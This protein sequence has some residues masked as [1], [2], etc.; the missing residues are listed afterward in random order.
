MFV[1]FEGKDVLVIGG[2]GVGT[3]RAKKFLKAKAKVKVFSLDF[4]DEL[5]EISGRVELI[6]GDV[7][8]TRKLEDFI[9]NSYLVVVALPFTDFNDK[10]VEI[11]KR[12]KTLV[13]LANDAKRTEVV[14]PF[15]G[16]FE[17]IRFAVTTEGK[18]G[19]VARRVKDT[20]LRALEEDEEIVSFLK[21]MDHLKR[22]MKGRN[23]PVQLRMKLYFAVS[24]D[25]KFRRLVRSGEVELAKEWAEK[26]VEDYVSGR[27][28]IEIEGFEF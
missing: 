4:S 3:S 11:A 9:K 23:I 22:Y 10:I 2:G 19:I 27:R 24:E 17:G 15:E 16:E 8:D 20:F 18:S 25:E 13:N 6:R 28:K 21:A 5:K 12:Y 7:K 1:E 14:I 26:L